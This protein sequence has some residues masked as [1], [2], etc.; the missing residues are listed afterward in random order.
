MAD[1][2]ARAET[3]GIIGA[4]NMAGA[5][6]R[7]L[8]RTGFPAAKLRAFD[9]DGAKTAALAGE[10]GITAA[11]TASEVVEN[12]AVVLLG[13]KPGLICAVAEEHRS[14]SANRLWISI[15]AGITTAKLERALGAEARV[16]RAMPNTPALISE[17]AT[18][19]CGGKYATSDDLDLAQTLLCAVGMTVAVTE[20][21]MDA[22]TAVSGS[23]PAFVMLVIEAMTDGGVRAGLPRALAQ[24]LAAQTVRGAAT[25]LQQTGKHPGELKDMVTSPGGTTIAGIEALEARGLRSAMIAGV[26]AAAARSRE[27]GEE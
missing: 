9:K 24:A 23:G 26:M 17:G 20:S 27:L 16:V 2:S 8:I 22:V 13:L 10:L 6:I 18:A 14:L 1:Q 3:V 5:L 15:A 4:G 25:L 11:P 21:M 19:I 7:G 12:S